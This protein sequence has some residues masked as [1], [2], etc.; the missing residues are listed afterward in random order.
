MRRLIAVMAALAT[1]GACGPDGDGGGVGGG[2]EPGGGYCESETSDGLHDTGKETRPAINMVPEHTS[3]CSDESFYAF[4]QEAYGDA[5]D[6][7]ISLIYTDNLERYGESPT[8]IRPDGYGGHSEDPECEGV[9]E[10]QDD[11]RHYCLI[12]I[13]D[14]SSHGKI[15]CDWHILSYVQGATCTYGVVCVPEAR[16]CELGFESPLD[17]ELCPWD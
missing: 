9:E 6:L 15:A 8:C 2:G 17:W 4:E 1:L 7:A 5:V 10:R 12:F 14:T 13:E 16:R 3:D 11:M